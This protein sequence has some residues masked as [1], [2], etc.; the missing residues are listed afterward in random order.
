MIE[1]SKE[2]LHSIVNTDLYPIHDLESKIRKDFV[3]GIFRELQK[4]GCAR[5]PS[6]FRSELIDEMA[7]EAETLHDQA[8]WPTE[9]Q[10]PYASQRDESFDAEHPR[11]FYTLR[12][13]GFIASDLLPLNSPLNRMYELDTLTHFVWET[14]KTG[15]PLYRYADPIAR[16]PYSV[17]EPGQDFPWHF[18]GNEFSISVL[19]QKAEKGGIFEYVPNIRAPGEE[20]YQSVKEVLNGDRTRVISL[21]LEPGDL[22][23]FKGRYSMHRV[24]KIEGARSRYI[25][26]PSYTHDP[27]RMNRPHHSV[28]YYGRSTALHAERELIPVDGLI[29]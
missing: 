25:G 23:I 6:F 21:D 20:N 14:L 28:T 22:Q 2:N 9:K 29:D 12:T 8:F 10:N 3:D 17:M 1:D 18:D 13:N 7:E 5:V 27:Y 11:N 19:V 26:I 15:K 4:N 16:N 24:S